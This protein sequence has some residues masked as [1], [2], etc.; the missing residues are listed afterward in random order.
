MRL[1]QINPSL[2]VNVE[3]AGIVCARKLYRQF[4]LLLLLKSHSNGKLQYNDELVRRL[5]NLYGYKSTKSIRSNIRRLEELRWISISKDNI[6]YVRSWQFFISYYKIKKKTVFNL[7]MN[8]IDSYKDLKSLL[9]SSVIGKCLNTRKFVARK[10]KNSSK[11]VNAD[12][13]LLEKLARRAMHKSGYPTFTKKPTI[14][15]VTGKETYM[16]SQ[17]SL[18]YLASMLYCSKTTAW[19]WLLDCELEGLIT[20]VKQNYDTKASNEHIDAMRSSLYEIAHRMYRDRDKDT[21]HIK[22]ANSLSHIMKFKSIKRYKY[23][24]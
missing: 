19:R 2:N 23:M 5:T 6:I 7:H 17:L 3:L 8:Y 13:C 20:V 21:V 11:N 22:L 24:K 9:I 10:Q 18:S 16:H 12:K 4:Y 14:D 1:E 15:L